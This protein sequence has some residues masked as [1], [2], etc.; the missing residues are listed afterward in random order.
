MQ[1]PKKGQTGEDMY[2]RHRSEGY[3]ICQADDDAAWTGRSLNR[4]RLVVH[5]HQRRHHRLLARGIGGSMQ[6]ACMIPVR[7]MRNTT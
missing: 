7:R 6:L 4:K 5:R 1:P 2:R 3:L